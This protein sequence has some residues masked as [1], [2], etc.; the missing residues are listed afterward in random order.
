M[1]ARLR[2]FTATDPCPIC[3]GHD[4]LGRGQGLRCFGY[5]DRS[6]PYCRGAPG[7]R[8]QGTSPQPG[9]HLHPPDSRPRP[10]PLR[11]VP[12]PVPVPRGQGP[13]RRPRHARAPCPAAIPLVPHARGLPPPPLRRG[14]HD[15]PLDLPR[16]RRDRGLPRAAHRLPGPRRHAGQELPPLPQGPRRQVAACRDR[17]CPCRSTTSR[18]SSPPRR[19]PSSP[20]PKA[21]NAPTSPRPSACPPPPPARTA[22][23]PRSSPT[24]R[25]WLA[26]PSPSSATRG[27]TAYPTPRRLPPSWPPSIPPPA[28]TSS[29]LSGLSDGEDIEQWIASR[30]QSG[31]PDA[32]ILAELRRPDRRG[33]L[34]SR[35]RLHALTPSWR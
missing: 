31:T 27:K 24:G 22:P 7:R 9:R 1:T 5:F 14:D 25:R 17:R 15:P 23:R 10:M 11:P 18:P 29:R 2:R 13:R 3:G 20:S 16:R 28:S 4:T 19:M 32:A 21:R 12:R 30:R 33:A 34:T 26:A 6:G 35:R 8:G